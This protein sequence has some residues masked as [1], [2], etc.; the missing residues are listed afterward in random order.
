MTVTRGESI[1]NP[2]GKNAESLIVNVLVTGN[3][4]YL[5]SVVCAD[6][7]AHGHRVVGFDIGYFA[8]CLSAEPVNPDEQRYGDVRSFAEDLHGIDAV[9]HLA[10]LS[11]DPLG[12]LNPELTAEINVGG[13]RRVAQ[14]AKAA[15]IARLVFASSCSLY[16]KSDGDAPLDEG[17]AQ[18]PLTA[19]ARSKVDGE[20]VLGELADQ[21]F[22]PISLRF[23]TAY[24]WSSRLRLDLVVNNLVAAGLAQ[25]VVALESDGTPWRPLVHVADMA[26]AIRLAL[27]SDVER[28][29]NTAYNVGAED[30]NYQVITVAERVADAL[31]G[32]PVTLKSSEESG[33]QRSYNVTFARFRQAFPTFVPDWTLQRGVA[34]L[35]QRMKPVMDAA[36]FAGPRY[37]RI[38]RIRELLAS[39]A[40]DPTLHYFSDS[41]V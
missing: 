24:G 4:G 7:R 39:G 21:R 12:E 2:I 3:L 13:L 16:G 25:G 23:A 29:G 18:N 26:Q 17:C 9:V 15:G 38:R 34:E 11:N 14:A 8:D 33:D 20:R 35:V 32:F 30:E 19:Y 27:E 10:A 37:F 6:L 41:S 1:L 5:G 36:T 28:T 40:I 31:G 22:R